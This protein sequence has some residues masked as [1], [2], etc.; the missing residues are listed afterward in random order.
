M[1]VD[2]QN[3]VWGE[4]ATG[5]LA[6]GTCPVR[7]LADEHKLPQTTPK[8]TFRH[9]AGQLAR[10]TAATAPSRGGRPNWIRAAK[11]SPPALSR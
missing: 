5:F 6:A 8:P 10:A 7:R 2:V 3:H 9:R 11:P 1:T 4:R